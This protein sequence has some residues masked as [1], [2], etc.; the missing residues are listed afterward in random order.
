[1]LNVNILDPRMELGV[2]NQSH[3][4]LIVAID[5]YRLD[6]LILEIELI[7]KITQSNRFFDNLR[8][9]DILGFI[10]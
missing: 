10:D 1:M 5:Y 7:E 8:L 2:L 4:P 3:S 6:S 9:V